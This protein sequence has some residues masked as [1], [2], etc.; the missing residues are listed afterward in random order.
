MADPAF[1]AKANPANVKAALGIAGKAVDRFPRDLY[2][3]FTRNGNR[4]HYQAWREKFL[5][6]LDALVSG[7]VAERKGRFLPAIA[8]RLDALC[9]WP[10]WVLPAHDRSLDEFNGKWRSPDLVSTELARHLARILWSVGDRLPAETVARVR[11]EV[12]E[13]VFR[14]YLEWPEKLW[15]FQ[16]G[17]NWNAVCHCGCVI[18]A[19][20]MV[21]DRMTRARFVEGAER[22]GKVFLAKGFEADGYCSE[23]MSYWNYGF[24]HFIDLTLAVRRATGGAVDYCS[25]PRALAA[26]RYG[27]TDQLVRGVSPKFADGDGNPDKGVVARGLEIWP[28]LKGVA[29]APLPLRSVFPDGQVWLMRLLAADS[30][31]FAFA[32]KGGHNG[33]HHNH[34][35]VGS[36][37]VLV[38]GKLVSGDVGGEVYT[39]R[40]FSPRRYESKV[41]SSYGHPVPRVGGRL[42]VLGRA[43]AAKVV[44]ADFTEQKDSVVLDLAKAY[45]CPTLTALTRTFVFDR[46]KRTVAITDNVSFSAPT[47]FESPVM[48]T[49]PQSLKGRFSV[50]ATGGDWEKSVEAIENPDRPTAHRIAIRFKEPVVEAS[51]SFVFSCGL[52]G[53]TP[54]GRIQEK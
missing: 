22:G 11:H 45:D 54:C 53:Q 31:S 33:E 38:D 8:E 34:N 9:G 50:S 40:T 21:E 12:N 32:C 39:A 47:A 1:C 30:A 10:S 13:R 27:L 35:D 14:P 37:N 4:T 41:L 28:E 44:K 5:K 24:G 23:G 16:G 43:A 7:E 29:D 52:N 48:T 25:S 6:A 15:W 2:L 3:E 18:A 36:Y 17:N 46:L 20:S 26:M 51:V 49:N 42:Q 19:L